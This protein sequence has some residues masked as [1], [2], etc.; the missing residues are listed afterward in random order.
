M[1][2]PPPKE[3]KTGWHGEPCHGL[4]GSRKL[5]TASSATE[6]GARTGAVLS[7]VLHTGLSG[8]S[9][10]TLGTESEDT[11]RL[12]RS[13]GATRCGTPA[14][15][16]YRGKAQMATDGNEPVG[17][18]W[19]SLVETGLLV[20]CTEMSRQ[21]LAAIRTSD[22]I[23]TE[24]VSAAFRPRRT[25]GRQTVPRTISLETT[26]QSAAGAVGSSSGGGALLA[27]VNGHRRCWD[28]STN[29]GSRLQGIDPVRSP[30]SHTA[31]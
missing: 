9:A 26:G 29:R 19:G 1:P 3:R 31:G 11:V 22:T 24:A 14:R 25:I 13:A 27:C 18:G 23:K 15:V 21:P 12:D 17:R 6:P 4:R 20:P 2:D 16:R 8:A 30:L 7:K 28:N 5:P 10:P